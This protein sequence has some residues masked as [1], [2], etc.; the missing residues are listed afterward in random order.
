MA[1]SSRSDKSG[2][3]SSQ[4]GGRKAADTGTERVYAEYSNRSNVL[5]PESAGSTGGKE[6]YTL[7]FSTVFQYETELIDKRREAL[8]LDRVKP[9]SGEEKKNTGI[10]TFGPY[11]R[12]E[13][14]PALGMTGLALSGG[15]IRSAAFCMGVTQ[16]MDALVVE[17]GSASRRG[18]QKSKP[19]S[20]FSHMDYLSTVSGGG[21]VGATLSAS[22][23]D[24]DGEFPFPSRLTKDE[25]L[26]LQHIRDH[27]NYLFPR[28]GIWEKIKNLMSYVRGIAA[29]IPLVICMLAF[30]LLLT[31]FSKGELVR[32][33]DP[34][35]FNIGLSCSAYKEN[36]CPSL[37]TSLQWLFVENSGFFALTVLLGLLFP[38]LL[39]FWALFRSAKSRAPFETKTAGTAVM[40]GIAI[41]LVLIF[42]MELQPKMVSGLH[43]NHCQKLA[44]ARPE[45]DE[46]LS[47]RSAE[48]QASDCSDVGI[49]FVQTTSGTSSESGGEGADKA[50]KGTTLI[51]SIVNRI[52]EITVI[53]AGFTG[54]FAA[55]RGIFGSGEAHSSQQR[56]LLGVLG[57]YSQMISQLI[58][59]LLLP[60]ALWIAYL[61]LAF[62]SMAGGMLKGPA[63]FM[64]AP[65]WFGAV[66]EAVHSSQLISIPFVY[67]MIFIAFFLIALFIK[68]NA[69]SPHNLYRDSLARAFIVRSR[70]DGENE[71]L[72]TGP[73]IR[74]MKLSGLCNAGTH[75]CKA[76]VHLI[77]A[78]LN[79]QGSQS[80]NGRGR[81]AGFFTFSGGYS[82]S[83]ETGFV[84][85]RDLEAA[86]KGEFTL[87]SA[88][89]ISAAAASSAMGSQTM[90]PLAATF[91]LLNVRLGYWLTNPRQIARHVSKYGREV[92]GKSKLVSR[93]QSRGLWLFFK[94]LGSMDEKDPL[95]YLSDGGHIEN[96]GLYGLLR[97]RCKL[98]VVVDAEADPG[99]TFS[100]FMSVQRYA[101]ID[102]G[103]RI[104]LQ[105]D[106]IREANTKARAALNPGILKGRSDKDELSALPED[107]PHCAVGTIDYPNDKKGNPV[108]GLMIYIKLSITGDEN[109][110][111]REYARKYRQF[112]HETTGDQFFSE[113]QFEAYRALGFHAAFK[114]LKGEKPVQIEKRTVFLR[115]QRSGE[116]RSLQDGD[117]NAPLKMF[118]K[119]FPEIRARTSSDA[120]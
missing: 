29:N 58:A 111:V 95:V 102:L 49:E 13:D 99:M 104:N 109:G 82:G 9:L 90:R 61:Y 14:L 34:S 69:N 4:R 27:S 91:A 96:L 87:S 39:L 119:A 86:H 46:M 51:Q 110:Y 72:E 50:G 70:K 41:L 83:Y 53:I 40:G 106:L 15:G 100:S 45:N 24:G 21:Y 7:P 18:S 117:E 79:I 56:G 85:T 47:K 6:D 59:G 60:L 31:T 64:H 114:A 36:Q 93:F 19:I 11:D 62:W 74:N 78:A 118:L 55:I 57:K 28:G 3:A 44:D 65:Q 103:T 17:R 35:F 5:T 33:N 48:F 84:D 113:E 92:L 105:T 22:L 54:L 67:A 66:A 8:G 26:V 75:G 98:I 101:R 30:A 63:N 115:K 2:N 25:S 71:T 38:F 37:L 23:Q 1:E 107:G 94:E 20:V 80:V 52:Q 116:K 32:L 73:E 112:P 68:P 77:N 108:T 88:V 97:R 89:A 16:A 10:K 81:N 43:A 12:S 120:G 76:P 42:G